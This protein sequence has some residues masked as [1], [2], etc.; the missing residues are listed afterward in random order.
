MKKG[1]L[2]ITAA[3]LVVLLALTSAPLAG[4]AQL[5][6][7]FPALPDLDTYFGS[8]AEAAATQP[9]NELIDGSDGTLTRAQWL[10]NLAVLFSMEVKDGL[11]PDNY[12]SDLES[13]SEYYYDVLLNVEFGVIDIEAGGALQPD[14]PATRMFAAQTLNYC[15]GYQLAE[16][17]QYTFADAQLCAYPDDAQIAVDMEWFAL[18]DGN[19]SPDALLTAEE[20][21]VMTTHAQQ[22]LAQQDIDEEYDSTFVLSD[23]VTLIDETTQTSIQTDAEQT[24]ITLVAPDIDFQ[25]EQLIAVMQQ[26]L[27]VVYKVLSVAEQENTVILTATEFTQ[28]SLFEEIDAQGTI[29]PDFS[30]IALAEDEDTQSDV[31][32]VN[33]DTGDEYETYAAALAVIGDKKKLKTAKVS[34]EINLKNGISLSVETKVSNPVVYYGIDTKDLSASVYF[35][36][37]VDT[38]YE[39]KGDIVEGFYKRLTEKKLF[40][41]GG[42]IHFYLDAELSGSVQAVSSSYMKTGI[43]YKGGTFRVIRNFKAESFE[44]VVNA[45]GKIGIKAKVGLDV[46]LIQANLYAAAGGKFTVDAKLVNDQTCVDF[47]AFVYA[48]LGASC[49]FDFIIFEVSQN[50]EYP[51]WDASN[52]PLKIHKHYDNWTE[53]ARCQFGASDGRPYYFTKWDS[54]VGGSG[55]TGTTGRGGL[56]SDGVTFVPTYTYTLDGDG[57]ATV[58]GYNAN[59]ATLRIPAEID[60]H[61][62]IAIGKEAFKN[63]AMVTLILPD[64]VKTIN[65]GAFYH[66]RNLRNVELSDTLEVMHHGAFEGTAIDSIVIPKTLRQCTTT[67]DNL[68]YS[69]NGPFNDCANLATVIFEDGITVIAPSLFAG[70]TGLKRIVIPD[71]VTTIKDKAFLHCINLRSVQLSANLVSIDTAAFKDCTSLTAIELPG[72]LETLGK[73]VFTNTLLTEVKI[74]RSLKSCSVTYSNLDYTGFDGPFSECEYF[75]SA[76]FEDGT[77]AIA[78]AVFAGCHNLTSVTIPDTVTSIGE[79]AFAQCLRL[80]EID[81]PDTILT[82]GFAAFARC[83]SLE[84]IELPAALQYIK[85]AAFKGA[86][87]KSITIPKHVLG[88]DLTYGNLDYTGY[89]GPFMENE[90]LQTV[91]FEDGMKTIP[92]GILAG[93]SY[94]TKVTIPESVT[95][96]DNKAFGLCTSLAEIKLPKGLTKI[97]FAAFYGNTAMK[98]IELPA[99]ITT[100]GNSVFATSGLE[101][102][103]LP[104]SLTSIGKYILGGCP[105]L[106]SVVLPATMTVVPQSMFLN[107][108]ALE[109]VELPANITTIS[110]EAFKNC[111][112]LSQVVFNNT[113]KTIGNNAFENCDALQTITIP[114]SVTSLGDCVFYDCDT[115]TDVSLGTGITVIPTKAF[116][117]CDMLA[118]MTLPYRTAT[119]NSNAFVECVKLTQITI[120][121]SV[122]QANENAFSYPGI[123]T[124][125]GVAGT[126]AETY[127]STIGAT[128]EDR[129]VSASAVTLDK[130]SLT[131]NKGKTEKL[132]LSI[133]PADFTDA[134]VWKSS[135]ADVVT[136]AEDGTLTA[137]NVGTAVIKV[138]VGNVSTSCSVT[139]TQ[140][141]TKVNIDKSSVTLQA[142]EEYQLKVTVSPDNA[143]DRRVKWSSSDESIACVDENGLVTTHKKGQA[144]I[145]AEAMDG[146]GQADTCTVTVSNS[147]FIVTDVAMLESPHNYEVNC[148]DF[149]QY[150]LDGA[151]QIY[152]TFDENTCI[153][154]GFDY[155]YILDA[156]GNQVGSYTGTQLAGATVCVPGDT[157]RIQLDSDDS[158]TEWGFRVTAVTTDVQEPDSFTDSENAKQN[159]EDIVMVAGLSVQQLL[160]QAPDGAVLQDKNGNELAADAP[161]VNGM[162]LVFAD[163]REFTVIVYGDTD[164]DGAVSASDARLALRTS[165]GLESYAAESAEYKA[166]NVDSAD[167]LSASDARLILRASVGLENAKD[168]LQ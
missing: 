142:L 58:T 23:D 37:D 91:V 163:A 88:C 133:A 98:N 118:V 71:S 57:N 16:D 34:T 139:V 49:T 131:I 76:E 50:L 105:S 55:Y 114:D 15:L 129:Q 109:K 122:T 150:T 86:N 152:V 40:T 141:V 43:E 75:E 124:V 85:K 158:S 145:R 77:T 14:A 29:S 9:Q 67:Y 94:V 93:C 108:G 127:A 99:G 115:L 73:K 148:N 68:D 143:N 112:A 31:V 72:A 6:F 19:F 128:F 146:S 62:V 51:I 104:D 2:K 137:K 54:L 74:P 39:I 84:S 87:L 123:L 61:T 8:E 101:T 5:N 110:S 89:D 63:K 45:T 80:S 42:L 13:T 12:F 161:A 24:L 18:T 56:H 53:V 1:F 79:K 125:Y 44:V 64:T 52:S 28:E 10:H 138:S 60:G 159:G 130:T 100:L 4:F 134:V 78:H 164:C 83:E 20:V 160:T 59:P 154:D 165:V 132:N 97:N 153:E 81:L 166:A 119:I 135:N 107:S 96:I 103:T 90:N 121:R 66:C 147:G 162:K 21:S 25:A 82:I 11:Y 17:A 126:Y 155:L 157:V 38:T 7:D 151:Q 35:D 65:Q 47:N 144:V 48:S 120:P 136:I 167:Q 106:K 116:G 27:P 36:C 102:I 32:Y 111:S 95:V 3:V 140:P 30:D 22:V 26:G 46:S 70:C 41:V 149:W 92:T 117:H 113:V 69:Y 33:E 168:W 156:D